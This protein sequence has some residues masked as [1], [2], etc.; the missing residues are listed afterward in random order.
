MRVPNRGSATALDGVVRADSA[1]QGAAGGAVVPGVV[2]AAL[3]AVQQGI[4]M[5]GRTD[6]RI[7]S[8]GKD[9]T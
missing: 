7:L 4:G 5:A 1:S 2:V 6:A 8:G 3:G 9:Y